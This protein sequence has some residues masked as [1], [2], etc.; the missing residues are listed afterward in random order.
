[1]F[2]FNP[3]KFP[4]LLVSFIVVILF[5][6]FSLPLKSGLFSLFSLPLE[7]TSSFIADTK[8]VITYKFIL[9]ENRGLKKEIS[10]SKSDSLRVNELQ[11]E[12]ERLK[13][14]LSLKDSYQFKTVAAKVIAR[15]P[16]NRSTGII[17]SQ[18][19]GQGIMPGNLVINDEGL[20][21]RILEVSRSASK[22]M[23]LNDPDSAVGAF[24]QRTREEGL[25]LGTLLG[26]L[27]MRYL[28]KDSGVRA[29]DM[30]LASGINQELPFGV[31]IGTVEALKDEEQ[32]L[33]KHCVVRPAV[34]LKRIEEV[35]VIVGKE[36][37]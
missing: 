2:K 17:I 4:P 7:I 30:V 8:A 12:N 28:E 24:I 1:M 21:G 34:N 20:V 26:G 10:R 23:L 11:L 6:V 25:V 16:E 5:F 36:R 27:V 3:A 19:S 14:L 32:G 33:G 31:L 18:G 35:L 15:D 37:L 13:K 9:N 29:G 22:I